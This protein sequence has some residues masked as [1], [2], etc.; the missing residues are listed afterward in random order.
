MWIPELLSAVPALEGSA[1]KL[2]KL[3]PQLISSERAARIAHIA[4][5]RLSGI[6]VAVEVRKMKQRKSDERRERREKG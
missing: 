5:Q 6:E 3:L 4:S 2:T 1:R